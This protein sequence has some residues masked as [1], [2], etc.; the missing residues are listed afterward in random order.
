VRSGNYGVSGVFK[1]LLLNGGGYTPRI[2]AV[3]ANLPW[4]LPVGADATIPFPTGTNTSNYIHWIR[5]G[6]PEDGFVDSV[7]IPRFNRMTAGSI[8]NQFSV[9][10]SDEETQ[11]LRPT[12]LVT[13]NAWGNATWTAA[14]EN[15]PTYAARHWR[16][17]NLGEAFY[18]HGG[19]PVWVAWRYQT[20]SITGTGGVAGQLIHDP[21]AAMATS[22]YTAGVRGSVRTKNVK[23][24]AA[25]TPS[26]LLSTFSWDEAAA[27]GVVGV[28]SLSTSDHLSTVVLGL[29]YRRA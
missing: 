6:I 20:S 29:G 24:Y 17:V 7:W 13:A 28:E 8:D 14:E 3:R 9:W 5:C 1:K 21:R 11:D 16:K 19:R 26:G 15:T 2:V 25:T 10:F 12:S 27:D 18:L 22:L 4:L 23:A